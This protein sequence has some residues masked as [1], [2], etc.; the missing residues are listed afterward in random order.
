MGIGRRSGIRAHDLLDPNQARYQ[1]ALHAVLV[2]PA[3]IRTSGPAVMR[4]PL[5]ASELRDHVV[6]SPDTIP[7]PWSSEDH[8]LLLSYEGIGG[9][10]P[11]S[12]GG[13]RLFR[14]T[15]LPA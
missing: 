12:N 1:A 5:Y 10:T 14:P 11:I 6:P 9:F 13:L 4:G 7:G 8:A 3:W 2:P 15:L